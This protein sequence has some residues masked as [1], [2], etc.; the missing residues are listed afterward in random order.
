MSPGRFEGS[1]IGSLI[2][3]DPSL[4]SFRNAPKGLFDFVETYTFRNES[5]STIPIYAVDCISNRATSSTFTEPHIGSPQYIAYSDT[6]LYTTNITYNVPFNFDG[7]VSAGTVSFVDGSSGVNNY[8]LAWSP[9]NLAV[10]YAANA[11][12]S[13]T[14]IAGRVRGSDYSVAATP[15]P[16][17][18]DNYSG[19]AAAYSVRLLNSSYT[20]SCMEVQ[21]GDGQYQSIGFDSNGDL[22]TAAIKTFCDDDTSETPTVGTVRTWY[23]Q[24]GSGNHAT[25]SDTTKQPQIYNGTTVL[26]KNGKPAAVFDGSSDYMDMPDNM[27]PAN[28]N[29][30]SVF[31]VQTNESSPNGATFNM[32]G[33][34]PNDRWFQT[35][36]VSNTEYFGYGSSFQAIT[37]GA[38]TTS[39]RLITAIAGSTQGNAQCFVDGTSQGSATLASI[40]PA[41]GTG[42]IVRSG[43]L[44]SGTFQEI[45]VYHSDQSTNRTTIESN[46]NAYYG[47]YNDPNWPDTTVTWGDYP[48]AGAY[49]L[50]PDLFLKAGFGN[51]YINLYS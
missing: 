33:Y 27:L 50:Y 39:Q 10:Q 44:A 40:S 4:I 46:I 16:P 47:I 48:D 18:L 31:T 12:V 51:V 45:I 5:P 24:S 41:A 22:D 43:Y 7:S 34:G 15:I 8:R 1:A 13:G 25:Q 3:L 21:R 9:D 11:T 19:A 38:A 14:D 20:G 49:E 35:I 30:C 36:V 42:E 32:G 2:Y 26:T 29:N 23:D 17:V 6:D 37:I 28:I